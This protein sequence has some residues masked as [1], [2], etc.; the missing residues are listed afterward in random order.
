MEFLPSYNG[1]MN[2]LYNFKFE[3][4]STGLPIYF[5]RNSNLNYLFSQ[6]EQAPSAVKGSPKP[7]GLTEFALK[8][9]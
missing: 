5:T 7:A 2:A 3:C 6:L 9:F 8:G 4:Q 1:F